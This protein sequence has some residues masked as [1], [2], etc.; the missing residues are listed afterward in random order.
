MNWLELH[1]H[2]LGILADS[3]TFL[4]AAILARDAF[5]HIRDLKKA[6]IDDKFRDEMP[7]LNLT[8]DELNEAIRARWWTF[9]GFALLVFGF[10][11][12]ILLRLLEK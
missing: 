8:D 2:L 11:F 3:L 4:G 9:A 10:F 12:Q 5:L 1:H 6:R 7:G